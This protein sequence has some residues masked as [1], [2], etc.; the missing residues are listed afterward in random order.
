MPLVA[1]LTFVV[2]SFLPSKCDIRFSCSISASPLSFAHSKG[3]EWDEEGKGKG[4]ES[5]G[6]N[7]ADTLPTMGIGNK[8]DYPK[9]D[10]S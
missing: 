2:S 7:A 1:E 8:Q 9:L 5:N 4:Q 3:G 10:T 6:E